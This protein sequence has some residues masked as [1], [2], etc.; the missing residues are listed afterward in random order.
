M[1]PGYGQSGYCSVCDSDRSREINKRMKRGDT[2]ASIYRWLRDVEDPISEP[3]LRKHRKHITDPKTTLVEQAKK[4]PVIKRHTT[5]D[6]LQALVDIAATKAINDPESISI[7]QGIRAAQ[8]IE[9]RKDKQ[10]DALVQIARMLMG[11]APRPEI[12]EGEYV[13]VKEL[14]TSGNERTEGSGAR[15]EPAG[16]DRE[17]TGRY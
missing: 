10:V 6:F 7:D 11:Q 4:N 9:G 1:K 15:Q 5:N 2:I 3:T 17:G 12:I 8:V 13:E 16:I 14:Q